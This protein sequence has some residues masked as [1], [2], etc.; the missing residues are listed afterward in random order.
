[1][2]DQAQTPDPK[3]APAAKAPTKEKVA[4]KPKASA[5][6]K[7]ATKAPAQKAAAPAKPKTTS[8]KAVSNIRKGGKP[9]KPGD[10][11]ELTE[12]EAVELKAAKAI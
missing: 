4:A 5:R 3:A 7:A 2:S 12:A 10:P 11:I 8:F 9:Y 1:M 6:T